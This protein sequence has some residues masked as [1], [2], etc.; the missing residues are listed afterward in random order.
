MVLKGAEFDPWEAE[1]I[2]E[3]AENNDLSQSEVL[4]RA[5]N[6]YLDLDN[7]KGEPDSFT[8]DQDK[9]TMLMDYGEDHEDRLT[10]LEDNFVELVAI[11]AYENVDVSDIDS[12][13]RR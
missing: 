8:V 1:E 11:L 5:V 3:Y 2:E 10:A 13:Y 6:E 4:R 9:I 7:M 12:K